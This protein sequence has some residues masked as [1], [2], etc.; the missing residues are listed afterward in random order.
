M[1]NIYNN[2][3]TDSTTVPNRFID[4]Y[5]TDANDAQLKVYLYLVRMMGARR[6][7]SISDLAD[8]F[9]HTEKDILRALRYW[10]RKGV[11]SLDLG[12]NGEIL[13]INLCDLSA[14]PR[15]S[16]SG[17]VIPITPMLERTE[18]AAAT[19]KKAG[20]S[21]PESSSSSPESGAVPAKK[22]PSAAQLSA[23][24]E[25]E[26]S[27]QLLFIVE[28]YIGKPLSVSEVRTVFYIS[29]QLD[30]SD[31]LIDYLVQYCVDRGKKD[32]RYIEKVAVNWAENGITTPKQAEN[33]VALAS[34]TGR[35]RI[36]RAGAA[37]FTQFEHHQYDFDQLEKELLNN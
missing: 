28:K 15:P 9:N 5:M 2:T 3:Q 35:K 27:A 17:R 1:F 32:F 13:G 33:A 11:L 10:E 16:S 22:V 24:R 20:A 14:A 36:P 12:D 21:L 29:E 19:R 4:E 31:D 7:T 26:H 34:K 6:G 30:F 23:F 18:D 25:R 8:Q 37:S